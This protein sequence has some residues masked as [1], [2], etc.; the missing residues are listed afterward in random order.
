M[1]TLLESIS[2]CASATHSESKPTWTSLTDIGSD[3]HGDV[4][5]IECPLAFESVA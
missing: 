3:S 5:G 2:L 4:K 1:R